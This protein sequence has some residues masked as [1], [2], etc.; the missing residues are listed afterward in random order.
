MKKGELFIGVTMTGIGI[1]VSIDSY[2]MGLHSI[3]NPGPGFF[4]F[5]LGMLL[6]ILT[7]PICI[8]SIGSVRKVATEEKFI[9]NPSNSI[10]LSLIVACLLGYFFLLDTLGFP[11][12][13]FIF[14]FVLFWSGYPRRWVFISTFSIVLVALAYLIFAYLLQTPFP[15]GFLAQ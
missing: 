14:L 12:I 9:R 2:R 11:I 4:P 15:L 6:C 8:R 13:T 1:W 7:L 3:T 10:K 5:V